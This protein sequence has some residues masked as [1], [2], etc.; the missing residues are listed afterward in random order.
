VTQLSKLASSVR[1]D[2]LMLSNNSS[3]S[4][5]ALQRSFCSPC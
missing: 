3:T 2:D 1:Y 4:I 5:S